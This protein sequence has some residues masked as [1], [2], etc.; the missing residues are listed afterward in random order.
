M[1]R[2]GL[3]LLVL[4][5]A[6]F[7]CNAQ[8]RPVAIEKIDSLMMLQRKPVLV[9]LTA[10]WCKYCMLQKSLLSKNKFFTEN[11]ET[12]YYT[13]LDAEGSKE[14]IKFN[15]KVYTYKN[16][17]SANGVNDLAEVLNGSSALSYPT[18]IILTEDYKVLRRF[19][20]V[21]ND[22]QLRTVIGSLQKVTNN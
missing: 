12:F 3:L 18:W 6:S 2:S 1:Q 11:A 19:N 13:E 10:P 4:L 21:L 20:G 8:T 7:I 9:L 15:N 5:L 22:K 16:S 17:G 14:P